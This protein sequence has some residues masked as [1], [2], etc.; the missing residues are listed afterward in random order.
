M[1]KR[2]LI[3]KMA[4]QSTLTSTQSKEALDVFCRIVKETLRNEEKIQIAGFG[5]FETTERGSRVGRNPQTGKTL[6]I[7][8]R[9]VPKFKPGKSLKDMVSGVN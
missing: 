9:R 7:A 3:E 6:E 8:A 1:N 2:E 5:T 4:R